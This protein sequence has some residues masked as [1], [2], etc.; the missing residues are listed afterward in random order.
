MV[1]IPIGRWK[2]WLEDYFSLFCFD[3]RGK[4]KKKKGGGIKK[5]KKT[6][7]RFTP[8]FEFSAQSGIGKGILCNKLFRN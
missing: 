2:D 1:S 6:R 3:E 8:T 5:I 7:A 4:K